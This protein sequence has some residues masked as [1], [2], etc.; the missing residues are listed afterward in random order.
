MKNSI[1]L[2]F[3]LFLNIQF[4][5]AQKRISISGNDEITMGTTVYANRCGWQEK[6]QIPYDAKTVTFNANGWWK[7][8][9][10]S[11]KSSGKHHKDS[12]SLLKHVNVMA[13]VAKITDGNNIYYMDFS[14][15]TTW[16]FTFNSDYAYIQFAVNDGDCS[17]N[18]GTI[19][20]YFDYEE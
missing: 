13:V 9:G 18:E 17:D 6:H 15:T 10:E 8:N 4:V 5:I 11:F 3:A 20:V 7:S 12:R 14:S 16:T 19:M 1:I 2:F